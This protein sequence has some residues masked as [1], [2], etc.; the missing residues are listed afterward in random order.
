MNCSSANFAYEKRTAQMSAVPDIPSVPD[1][2]L[3]R[4]VSINNLGCALQAGAPLFR[5]GGNHHGGHRGFPYISG[6]NRFGFY[7]EQKSGN[8]KESE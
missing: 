2:A 1:S 4:A 3:K 6:V 7:L 5:F 8:E